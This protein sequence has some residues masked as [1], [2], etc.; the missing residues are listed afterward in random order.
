VQKFI[1]EI[2]NFAFNITISLIFIKVC[3]SKPNCLLSNHNHNIDT[4][5]RNN[6]YLSQANLTVY[7]K[8]AHYSGIKVFNNLPFE[9]K[10]V[11]DNPRKFKAALKQFYTLTLF[12]LRKNT[13][14]NHEL[15]TVLQNILLH[16]YMC[17][18]IGTSF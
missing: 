9:I 8:G 17:V 13:F 11:V 16:T 2:I 3:S 18:C 5:Q 4:R 6:F 1:Y 10:N 12:M 15:Y 7:Q 14:T